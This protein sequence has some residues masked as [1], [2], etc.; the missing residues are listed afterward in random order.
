MF[1]IFVT[2]DIQPDKVNEFIEASHGDAQ[3]ACRDEP[4]CFRFE[5]HQD[6]EVSNRFY[7][8]EVYRDEAA[9]QNHLEQPHFLAW[10]D[11]VK[12]LFLS[13]PHKVVMKTVWPSDEGYEKQKPALLNW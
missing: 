4:D 12:P 7:V 10:R 1:S 6:P 5:L 11:V 9:F 8:Y 3:G 2:I 13:D